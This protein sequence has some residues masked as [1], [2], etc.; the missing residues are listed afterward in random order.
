M[1][2]KLDPGETPPREMYPDLL[3]D[4]LDTILAST[5]ESQAS[6]APANISLDATQD[7]LGQNSPDTSSSAAASETLPSGKR[8][9]CC[10]Q[11]HTLNGHYCPPC[12]SAMTH[13]DNQ[14]VP[15]WSFAKMVEKSGPCCPIC[16]VQMIQSGGM[17]GYRAVL[18]HVHMSDVSIE[19]VISATTSDP[20]AGNQTKNAPVPNQ[21]PSDTLAA[22]PGII[23]STEVVATLAIASEEPVLIPSEDITP[24]QTRRGKRADAESKKKKLIGPPRGIICS[25][26]NILIGQLEDNIKHEGCTKADRLRNC[27]AWIEQRGHTS[28]LD[29]LDPV[30]QVPGAYRPRFDNPE[31]VCIP[32]ELRTKQ[33]PISPFYRT[34]VSASETITAALTPKKPRGKAKAAANTSD[35]ESTLHRT[36]TPSA[37]STPRRSDTPSSPSPQQFAAKTSVGR[38]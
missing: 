21:G 37:E 4:P 1:A 22:P 13:M 20:A 26:C 19:T 15:P 23:N 38:K 17:G 8:C 10:R 31:A 25:T 35:T 11:R 2:L 18:D 6:S 14:R 24:D 16:N 5:D 28:E 3:P 34:A 33:R 36:S 29:L 9:G 7:D 27:L 12:S 32:L 30:D